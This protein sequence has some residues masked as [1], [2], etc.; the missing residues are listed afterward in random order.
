M[1]HRSKLINSIGIIAR[2][3]KKP[4]NKISL[5]NPRLK[6]TKDPAIKLLIR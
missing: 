3:N 6:G 5:E 4:L 2:Y 1:C